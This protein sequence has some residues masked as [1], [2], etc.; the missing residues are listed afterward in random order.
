MEKVILKTKYIKALFDDE[1]KIYTSI[2]LHETQNMT[3]KEWQDQMF[4]LKTLIETY[5]P[6]FI[7]DDNTERMYGYSPEM[8]VWTL[9]LFVD[10]WN[11]I[12]LKKYAQ[13]IPREIVGKLT[14]SQIEEFAVSDFNMQFHHR[15]FDDCMSA[16]NWI[17]EKG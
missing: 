10:S 7:I 6:N 1:T 15:F 13:V 3:D 17:K 4:E 11:K 5:K 9:H 14:S 8:Q 16:I 12:G 2:Y